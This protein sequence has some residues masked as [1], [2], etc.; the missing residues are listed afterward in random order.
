MKPLHMQPR[1]G[2]VWRHWAFLVTS[3]TEDGDVYTMEVV[4]RDRRQAIGKARDYGLAGRI[5]E[6]RLLGATLL[7]EGVYERPE[8]VLT[9]VGMP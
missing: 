2:R 7:S 1:I 6:A 4:A 9:G 8:R 5:C 3:C